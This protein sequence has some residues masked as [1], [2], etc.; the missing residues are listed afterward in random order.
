MA[1]LQVAVN[2]YYA[3]ARIG[4]A[5]KLFDMIPCDIARFERLVF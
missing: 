1:Y 3:A 2:A 4:R 5:G